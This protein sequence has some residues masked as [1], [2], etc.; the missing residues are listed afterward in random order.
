MTDIAKSRWPW[1]ESKALEHDPTRYDYGTKDRLFTG[2]NEADGDPAG[3][4]GGDRESGGRGGTGRH[5]NQA[6][7]RMK[8]AQ[9]AQPSG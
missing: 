1:P 2:E 4:A 5:E 6:S 9:I 8:I 7:P 3:S